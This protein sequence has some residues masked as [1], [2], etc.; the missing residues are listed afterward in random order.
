MRKKRR[1][2]EARFLLWFIISMFKEYRFLKYDLLLRLYR[3]RC[4]YLSFSIFM[5]QYLRTPSLSYTFPLACCS[6]ETEQIGGKRESER[7]KEA[8]R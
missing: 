6:V 1:E 8:D 2:K 5:F 4:M 7:E 3:L